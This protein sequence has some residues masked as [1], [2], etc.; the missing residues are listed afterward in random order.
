M[1]RFN[2]ASSYILLDIT[3][4]SMCVGSRGP[5]EYNYGM[6]QLMET[7]YEYALT[8]ASHCYIPGIHMIYVGIYDIMFI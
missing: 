5:Q 8:T 3:L 2:I 6:L 4:L 7:Q 1:E